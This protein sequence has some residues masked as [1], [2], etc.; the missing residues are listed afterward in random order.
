MDEDLLRTS[1]TGFFII[2]L[3][4][5]FLSLWRVFEKAGEQG[6]KS[7]VPFYNFYTLLRIVGKPGWWVALL[8]VPGVNIVIFIWTA[9]LLSKSFGKGTGFTVGIVLLGFVF[10]PILAFDDSV[11]NGPLGNK[12]QAIS[13]KLKGYEFGKPRLAH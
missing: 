10:I 3:L 1:L 12:Q 11:Y 7:I 8:L 4:V 6:W 2:L 9:N 5:Q 13:Y